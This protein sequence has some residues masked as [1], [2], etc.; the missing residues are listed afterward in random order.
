LLNPGEIEMASTDLGKLKIDD[1]SP[2]VD[3]SF[4]MET[5]HGAVPLKLVAATANGTS[6]P[7]GT[8]GPKGEQIKARGA[9][10][11][12]LQFVAPQGRW[13]PQKIYPVKHPKLGTLEV[14]LVPTGPLHD[15][16]GYHAVFA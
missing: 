1:F 7:E 4:E 16:H 11:F 10:G 15:G 14:F 5:P 3:S 9:E 8:K 13:L 12:T 6:V 2:H